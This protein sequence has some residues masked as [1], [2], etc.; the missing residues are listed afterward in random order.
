MKNNALNGLHFIFLQQKRTNFMS[1]TTL[2]RCHLVEK[3]TYLF[4]KNLFQTNI[5]H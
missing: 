3:Q 4:T 5:H 1:D 2:Y